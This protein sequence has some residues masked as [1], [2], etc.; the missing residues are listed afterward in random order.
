[1]RLLPHIRK[2]GSRWLCTTCWLPEYEGAGPTPREA[3][4]SWKQVH[5]ATP[6]SVVVNAL[7]AYRERSTA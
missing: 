2:Q 5:F 3:Y 4:E 6:P 7:W 1:M